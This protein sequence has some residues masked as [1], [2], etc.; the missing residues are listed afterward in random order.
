MSSF[1]SNPADIETRSN[2]MASG[3]SWMRLVV[4]KFQSVVLN[5]FLFPSVCLAWLPRK[6][7]EL[8]VGTLLPFAFA[9]VVYA[10]YLIV[11]IM[12]NY[13]WSFYVASVLVIT[14]VSYKC[15]SIRYRSRVGIDVPTSNVALIDPS[16]VIVNDD[17]VM[18][19]DK[20]M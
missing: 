20:I 14:C 19:F 15:Y 18:E 17:K 3:M 8:T 4:N 1:Q 2:Y 9:A 10:L 12:G 5:L 11:S 16:I 7:Q 13:M 6:L